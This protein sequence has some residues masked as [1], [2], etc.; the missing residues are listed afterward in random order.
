M[1]YLSNIFCLGKT[2]HHDYEGKYILKDPTFD[3][4][5]TS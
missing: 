4:G 5:K 2:Y 1:Y 3:L